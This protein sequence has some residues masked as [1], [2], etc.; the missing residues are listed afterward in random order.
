[1][2]TRSYGSLQGLG[3]RWQDLLKYLMEVGGANLVFFKLSGIRVHVAGL[4]ETPRGSWCGDQVLW[5]LSGVEVHWAGF[6]TTPGGS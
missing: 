4:V 3:P 1:M 2:V 5:K 6:V